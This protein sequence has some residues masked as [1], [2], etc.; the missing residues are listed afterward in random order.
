MREK[1]SNYEFEIKLM[2]EDE[3]YRNKWYYLIYTEG[4]KPYDDGI[5]ESSEWFD[6]QQEARY[7]AIGHISLPENGE[8]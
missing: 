6:T 4:C 1:Y 3:Q 7:A 8:G 2:P 5:I